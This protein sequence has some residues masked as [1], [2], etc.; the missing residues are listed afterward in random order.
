MHQNVLAIQNLTTA[1]AHINRVLSFFSTSELFLHVLV[2]NAS[3]VQQRLKSHRLELT[4]VTH[5]C[6][7]DSY[8]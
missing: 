3:I 4:P 2:L 6:C 8:L 5:F 7:F 1:S